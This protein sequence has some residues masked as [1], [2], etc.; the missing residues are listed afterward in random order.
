M[1][2]KRRCSSVVFLLI[3]V[4]LWQE[5]FSSLRSVISKLHSMQ[6]RAE[7][8]LFGSSGHETAVP[9]RKTTLQV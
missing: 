7:Q 1:E 3:P 8:A 9:V 6:R 4:D 2:A 5:P